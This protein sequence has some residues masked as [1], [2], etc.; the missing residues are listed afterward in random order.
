MPSDRDTEEGLERLRAVV[1]ANPRSTAFVALA[2]ALCDSGREDEAEEV[3]RQGLGQHPHLVTGQVALGRALIARGRMR[4]AQERLVEAA[5]SSPENGDAFRWLGELVLRRGQPSKA[6]VLLEYAEELVPGDQR[7][8]ELLTEAGGVPQPRQTRPKTDFEN[9]RVGNLQTMRELAERMQEDPPP[10]KPKPTPKNGTA[11][12][13]EEAVTAEFEP[14]PARAK[15]GAA[16]PASVP[17]AQAAAGKGGSPAPP[18]GDKAEPGNPLPDLAAGALPPLAPPRPATPAKVKPG[19]ASAARKNG[20]KEEKNVDAKDGE[21]GAG[22]KGSLA[23]LWRDKT[24]RRVAAGALVVLLVGGVAA[25]RF[26]SASPPPPTGETGGA[27]ASDPA[28]PMVAAVDMTAAIAAGTLDGLSAVRALGK[29]VLEMQP[30]DPDQL[31]AA[32]FA[33]ALLA[34]DYGGAGNSDA[35]EMASAAE[36]VQPE[37]PVRTALIEGSRALVAV[38]G[39]HLDDARA[40]LERALK[41][42]PDSAE[43]LLVQ[44]RLALREGDLGT[45]VTALE[46]AVRREPTITS[47]ALD[48]AIA[49]LDGGNA[50]AA[51]GVLAPLVT[52]RNDLRALLLVAEAERAQGKPV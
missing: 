28:K 32:A 7:V 1:R 20:Q 38:T 43:A 14:R 21:E 15:N 12:R 40:A 2:H 41:A 16:P 5:K 11:A 10:A 36:K 39:G 23:S 25:W 26:R 45:A 52:A 24:G 47:A 46:K 50:A 18:T 6:R 27:A 29:R 9:T 51:E 34:N 33:S 22:F 17:N 44:G 30:S 13:A 49:H 42:A 8:A 4:E 35:L 3:A 19:T 31:A 48:L 37:R